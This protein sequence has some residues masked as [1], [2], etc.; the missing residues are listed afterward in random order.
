MG[1]MISPEPLMRDDKTGNV[2]TNLSLGKVKL[3]FAPHLA[4][5]VL[6]AQSNELHRAALTE[7]LL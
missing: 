6:Q 1:N 2:L 3:Y 4:R 7:H 5:F